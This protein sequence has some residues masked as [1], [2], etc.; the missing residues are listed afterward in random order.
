MSKYHAVITSIEDEIF[1]NLFYASLSYM[2]AG[3]LKWTN[4]SLSPEEKLAEF[5]GRC[6]ILLDRSNFA[7]KIEKEGLTLG[8]IF[9]DRTGLSFTAILGILRP[10]ASG[11]R[12]WIYDTE[13]KT[14][15]S[16]FAAENNLTSIQFAVTPGSSIE[17]AVKTRLNLVDGDFNHLNTEHPCSIVKVL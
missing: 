15:L 12:S 11:S 1:D 7:Y 3:T 10:D 8:M 9:G 17:N 16:D 13:L 2:D 5:K 6:N 4:D 14:S